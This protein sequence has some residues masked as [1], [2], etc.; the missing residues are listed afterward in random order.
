[1]RRSEQER[2]LEVGRGRYGEYSTEETRSTISW[3]LCSVKGLESPAELSLH[4]KIKI[5]TI[6]R[7]MLQCKTIPD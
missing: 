4:G 1:M 7:M 5:N 6:S 3:G 2:G